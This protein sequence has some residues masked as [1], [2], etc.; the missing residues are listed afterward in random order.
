M[1]TRTFMHRTPERAWKRVS[2]LH[3]HLVRTALITVMVYI[4]SGS[5]TI[6]PHISGSQIKQQI[7]FKKSM[8]KELKSF[9]LR[10]CLPLF[11]DTPLSSASVVFDPS[12]DQPIHGPAQLHSRI[13]S[14]RARRPHR[15]T[16]HPKAQPTRKCGI[17]PPTVTPSML[18]SPTCMLLRMLVWNRSRWTHHFYARLWLPRLLGSS[19]GRAC[20]G[21]YRGEA[22]GD[23]RAP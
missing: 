17:L 15:P 7:N 20:I 2:G 23:C 3:L 5:Y 18:T 4:I 16:W 10:T 13:F 22:C 8:E 6:Q 14:L 9:R 19:V 21:A 1:G 11:V 12:H